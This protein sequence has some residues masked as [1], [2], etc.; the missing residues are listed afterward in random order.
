M[1]KREELKKIGD[2]LYEVLAQ[3]NVTLNITEKWKGVVFYE[4]TYYA[5]F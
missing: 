5:N 4:S 1:S 3:K 2:E